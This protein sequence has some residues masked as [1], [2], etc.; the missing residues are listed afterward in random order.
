MAP[1]DDL[2]PKVPY[3]L[4][5]GVSSPRITH[6]DLTRVYNFKVQYDPPSL[7]IGSSTVSKFSTPGVVLGD[8]VMVAAPYDL[9]SVI[10]TGYVQ[11]VGTTV[12]VLYNGSTGVINL[13]AGSWTIK[14]LKAL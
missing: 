6:N 1:I 9:G 10:V 12:I 11:A 13:A 7:S 3:H 8:Y 2:F 4:H 14:I 5:D